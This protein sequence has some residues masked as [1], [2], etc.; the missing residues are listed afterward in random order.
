[1]YTKFG[2]DMVVVID[3][4]WV[5]KEKPSGGSVYKGKETIFFKHGIAAVCGHEQEKVKDSGIE[6]EKRTWI[7]QL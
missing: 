5:I 6:V 2:S 3:D 1:M 7:E 4:M